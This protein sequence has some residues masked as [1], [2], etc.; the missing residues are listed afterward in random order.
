MP[1]HLHPTPARHARIAT[2]ALA[3]A[4]CTML[5][6]CSGG[7]PWGATPQNL[8]Q[9]NLPSVEVVSARIDAGTNAGAQR[10]AERVR[11]ALLGQSALAGAQLGV[12]GFEGGLIVLSGRL[13]DAGQRALVL[14]TTR[15]VPGV[16][17]VADRM[18]AP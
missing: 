1:R 17:D 9:I 15:Q 2:A 8:P 13:A 10:L 4:A 11:N 14:S 12:E 5:A 18:T 7:T 3:L 16:G 6:A